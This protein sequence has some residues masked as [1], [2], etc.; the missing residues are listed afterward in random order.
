[1]YLG[2]EHKRAEPV[3]VLSPAGTPHSCAAGTVIMIDD[4]TSR[5]VHKAFERRMIR[6]DLRVLQG[7]T[8]EG[9]RLLQNFLEMKAG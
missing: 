9:P 3:S 5:S 4:A 6:D 8:L 7:V 2:T 1:M